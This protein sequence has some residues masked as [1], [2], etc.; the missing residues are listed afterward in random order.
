MERPHEIELKYAIADPEAVRVWLDE[1]DVPGLTRGSWR[2]RVDR[3]TYVDTSSRDLERAGYGARIRRRGGATTITLKSV[4]VDGNGAEPR[5]REEIEGPADGRLDPAAWPASAARELLTDLAGSEPLVPLFEL[6]QRRQVREVRHENGACAEISLD[7]AEV[8]RGRRHAGTFEALEI[9]ARD[10]D[11][12]A[13]ILEPLRDQVTSSGLATPDARSKLEIATG[14]VAALDD[15]EVGHRAFAALPKQPGVLPDDTIAEAGR[16]VLRLHLRRMLSM[17]AGTRSGSDPEDLHKMRVA[18]RRMRAAWRVFDGAYQPS[19]Q[20]RYVAELKQ[21]AGALGAVRDL[22]VQLDGLTEYGHGLPESGAEALGP[23]AELWQD[24]RGAARKALLDLLDSDEYG[25]FVDDYRAF[26]DEP[27]N[28]VKEPRPNEPSLVRETAGG[29]I[30]LAYER[31]RAHDATLR[32]ADAA[33]L[34][35]VRI[36]GKRLRYTLECFREALPR[37]QVDRLIATV[38][39]MQD[40]L[41]EHND[42]D[43]ASRAGR[44]FLVSQGSRLPESSREAI[45]HYVDSRTAEMAR[46]RRRVPALWRRLTGQP[47]RRTLASAIATL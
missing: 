36:D 3:D 12:V 37:Q 20:R 15:V 47:F 2:V 33:G 31:V 43:V 24:R 29:R 42:A 1:L 16:K 22:D 40:L 34:H 27:G 39:E 4:E 38:V 23:L 17:E 32:W 9:E 44:D 41:G 10:D 19:R 45:G 6:R 26:T 30:W 11:A 5:R 14:L 7:H 13:A 25:H 18:T 35:A 28:G 46:I 8:R 21:V